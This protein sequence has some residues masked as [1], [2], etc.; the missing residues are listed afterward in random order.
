MAIFIYPNPIFSYT[1][2]AHSLLVSLSLSL[3]L[4]V[5]CLVWNLFSLC[6]CNPRSM[7]RRLARHGTVFG[8]ANAD[9]A[10]VRTFEAWHELVK[11]AIAGSGSAEGASE[12]AVATLRKNIADDCVFRPPTYFKP[13]EGGDETALLLTCA[14]EVFGDSFTYGRQWISDDG[15]DWA[16]E[17]RAEIASSGKIV[18]GIDLVKLNADGKIADFTVLA[19]PPSGVSV[20]G[21]EMMKRVPQKMAKLKSKK[22]IRSATSAFSSVFGGSGKL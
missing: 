19:R 16:L 5:E 9:E 13:W 18:D 3:S 22:M 15:R 14:A 8:G 20:L 10:T 11:S 2:S 4:C 12:E 1:L 21:E 17:F 7:L 6:L